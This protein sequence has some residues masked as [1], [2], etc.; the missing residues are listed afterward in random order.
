MRLKAALVFLLITVSGVFGEDPPATDAPTTPPAPPPNPDP[1][2]CQ[3]RQPTSTTD[4]APAQ[5]TI[6][7]KFEMIAEVTNAVS[8]YL[9]IE[10]VNH[11]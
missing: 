5:P 10:W 3:T 6:A 11:L 9:I 4:P 7:D 8:L 2:K 1:V